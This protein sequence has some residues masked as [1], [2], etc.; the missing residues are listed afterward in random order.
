MSEQTGDL[1]NRE[2]GENVETNQEVTENLTGAVAPT[3]GEQSSDQQEAPSRIWQEE[4]RIDP[5][6]LNLKEEVVNLN[7]V[8]KVV[9]GGRR[10]SFSALV[11]VGDGNGHVGVGF[12][13]A[14]EVPEAISKG[15]EDAKKNLIKVP[16]KGRTIPH[17]LI[18][19]FG[20]ARVVLKPASVGTGLLAGPGV[21]AVLNAAGIHDILTKV[22]GTNNKIN[23]VKATLNG[24]AMLQNAEKLAQLRGRS[25][26]ELYGNEPITPAEAAPDYNTAAFETEE[27]NKE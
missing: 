8:A 15:S 13:K 23:V 7:R 3:E 9:K 5:K 6:S 12:G 4:E 1:G 16:M 21:R 20:A 2:E 11:I 24:L 26:Q 18:G 17:A 25:V 27:E 19:A 14:N 10:F 22:I